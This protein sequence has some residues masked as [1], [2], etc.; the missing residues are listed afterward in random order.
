MCPPGL[1]IHLVLPHGSIAERRALIGPRPAEWALGRSRAP[2]PASGF[3]IGASVGVSLSP[4]RVLLDPYEQ[5]PAAGKRA[6][7]EPYTG[8]VSRLAPMFVGLRVF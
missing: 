2:A 8:A 6:P 5:R 1:R 3:R 7:A 4:H